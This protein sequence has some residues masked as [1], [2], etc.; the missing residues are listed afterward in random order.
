MNGSFSLGEGGRRAAGRVLCLAA[1]IAVAAGSLSCGRR[2]A[3]ASTRPIESSVHA[4]FQALAEETWEQFVAVF[5]A[6]Q[7]CF[8]DVHL[9]AVYTLDSRA[10]YDPDTATVT[11]YVPGTPAML[12]S[13]LVHE[14]AHHVEFQCPEQEEM[15]AGF[16]AAQRLP[17]DTPWRPDELPAGLSTDQWAALPS[18]QFAEATVELVLGGRPI[19]AKAHVR[20]EAVAVVRRWAGCD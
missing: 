16:L 18:E 17:P 10:G 11:V 5:Q 8:G 7:G 13:A 20:Q 3:P 4:D 9:Q 19:A 2:S 12:Q 1:A 14:W 15:R 6:R